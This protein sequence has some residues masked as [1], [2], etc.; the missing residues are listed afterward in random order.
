MLGQRL[1]NLFLMIHVFLYRLS[2]G[3]LGGHFRG[4]PVLLL[5]TVGR[6]T[7]KRRTVP[8]LYIRDGANYV[9]TASNGGRNQ[10]PGWWLNLQ[11]NPQTTIE[12]ATDKISVLAEQAIAEEKKLLWEKLV[13]KAHFYVDYQKRTKRDIPMVILRPMV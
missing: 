1:I 2:G 4:L 6:K 3:A 8:L 13:D 5:T 12:V 7:G 10:N 11:S 9:I